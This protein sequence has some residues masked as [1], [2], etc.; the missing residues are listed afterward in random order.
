VIAVDAADDCP[1]SRS[2]HTRWGSPC[3][4]LSCPDA[5]VEQRSPASHRFIG[6]PLGARVMTSCSVPA[7][8]AS[9]GGE[10]FGRCGSRVDRCSNVA[11]DCRQGRS[12]EILKDTTTGWFSADRTRTDPTPRQHN[13]QCGGRLAD[14]PVIGHHPARNDLANCGWLAEYG[15]R[16]NRKLLTAH[17]KVLV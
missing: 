8:A 17:A 9:R 12:G 6:T 2:P 11:E 3:V 7:R 1:P 5:V 10:R 16:D 14:P 13:S 4:A 15:R